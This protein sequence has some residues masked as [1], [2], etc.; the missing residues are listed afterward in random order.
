[1]IAAVTLAL[2]IVISRNNVRETWPLNPVL[3][4]LAIGADIAAY[5]GRPASALFLLGLLIPVAVVYAWAWMRFRR[6]AP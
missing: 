2:L 4:A 5:M 1:M 3:L 6:W